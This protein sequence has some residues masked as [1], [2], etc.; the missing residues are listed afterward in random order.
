MH[1][2]TAYWDTKDTRFWRPSCSCRGN[3]AAARKGCERAM[4]IA[5]ARGARAPTPAPQ[6][7]PRPLHPRTMKPRAVVSGADTRVRGTAKNLVEAERRSAG[8]ALSAGRAR[9]QWYSTYDSLMRLLRTTCGVAGEGAAGSPRWPCM[10]RACRAQWRAVAPPAHLE[11]VVVRDLEVLGHRHLRGGAGWAQD[12]RAGGGIGPT[13]VYQAA[14]PEP[15]RAPPPHPTHRGGHIGAGVGGRLDAHAPKRRDVRAL[16]FSAR[17]A[18]A[19]RARGAL[20]DQ[21]RGQQQQSRSC[22]G[23]AAMHRGGCLAEQGLGRWGQGVGGC[24]EG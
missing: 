14:H 22:Q 15:A 18:L 4:Q 3:G 5:L 17:Q 10:A 13:Y 23:R 21:R 19:E 24:R 8:R 2:P 9:P 12:W 11:V 6:D 20:H 1:A 7:E 16:E